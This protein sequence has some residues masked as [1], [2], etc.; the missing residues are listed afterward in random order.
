MKT[1]KPAQL[2]VVVEMY[3]SGV[4]TIHGYAAICDVPIASIKKTLD[5]HK[6]A[7]SKA[8]RNR[9]LTGDEIIALVKKGK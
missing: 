5:V 9:N 4:G 6:V 1:L 8:S 2:S 7:H 3:R